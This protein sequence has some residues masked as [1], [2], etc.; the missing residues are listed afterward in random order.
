MKRFLICLLVGLNLFACSKD[1]DDENMSAEYYVKYH[2]KCSD[3]KRYVAFVINYTNEN[4]TTSKR[5]Y[6]YDNLRGGSSKYEDEIVCG[7]F[8]HG[9]M[10]KL[11]MS[12]VKY[13][14]SQLLEINVSKDNSPFALKKS[15]NSS[16][17]F[18]TIDY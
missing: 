10:I 1:S 11:S 15:S 12:D 16:S 5:S 3:A 8:K 2:F 6:G 7:P 14:S 17:V 4:L 9:D 18:Y 13:V